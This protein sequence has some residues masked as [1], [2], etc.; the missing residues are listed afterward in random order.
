M[1]NHATHDI[2]QTIHNDKVKVRR[3]QITRKATIMQQ[4][5]TKSQS[6]HDKY[7]PHLHTAS[8]A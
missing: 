4:M 5:F 6:V 3:S 1:N 7:K 2:S 8:A